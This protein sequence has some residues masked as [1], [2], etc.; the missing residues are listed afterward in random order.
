MAKTKV[1]VIV[2]L[3][4]VIALSLLAVCFG[5]LFSPAEAKAA[6]GTYD[7][8]AAVALM[9]DLII[10]G[11]ATLTENVV[12]DLTQQ[13][14]ILGSQLPDGLLRFL[15]TYSHKNVTIDL[16]GRTLEIITG[17]DK[18]CLHVADGITVT[19]KNGT[20]KG[21]SAGSFAWGETGSK[22]VLEDVDIKFETSSTETGAAGDEGMTPGGSSEDHVILSNGSVE[23]SGVTFDTN[24]SD[25]VAVFTKNAETGE[26]VGSD[27]TYGTLQDAINAT[28]YNEDIQ[29]SDKI[30]SVNAEEKSV[31]E[32]IVIPEGQKINL[33]LNGYTLKNVE[34]A[35]KYAAI[36]NN[37]ELYVY[38]GTIAATSAAKMSSSNDDD[39]IPYGIYNNGTLIA[40]N[41][42]IN[43]T[44]TGSG[45]SEDKPT[46]KVSIKAYGIYNNAG[47]VTISGGKV[48]ASSASYN[49]YALYNTKGALNINGGEYVVEDKSGSLTVYTIYSLNSGSS[50]KIN[51]GT[52]KADG[53]T[54]YGMYIKSGSEIS[55]ATIAAVGKKTTYGIYAN[56]CDV[57]I[58]DSS[59]TATTNAK[60]AGA[61]GIQGAYKVGL[62]LS[63]VAITAKAEQSIGRCISSNNSSA[64]FKALSISGEDTVL[65]AIS[66][67]EYKSKSYA[68]SI[69]G[70]E[71]NPNLLLKTVLSNPVDSNSVKERQQKY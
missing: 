25:P 45:N 52:F 34:E 28:G 2:A 10:D 40:S 46:A 43:A 16:G 41:V 11:Q 37:G 26:F 47:S 60:N 49:S 1:K 63:D 61:H 57:K 17:S 18:C 22:I 32:S 3:F 21:S 7:D 29:V 62:T 42:E 59:I 12:F 35:G 27:V 67:A 65:S 23:L 30:K 36:T 71:E 51:G 48:Y 69:Y 33:G 54:A 53:G 9:Q 50:I 20:L 70:S 58:S 66:G 44:A 55:N 56:T 68:V 5:R 13:S 24:V 19:V 38:N 31:T 39:Y 14:D 6:D 4:A 8:T 15:A 64:S